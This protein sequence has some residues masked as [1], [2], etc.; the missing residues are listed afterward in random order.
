M[1][2]ICGII[3]P[4]RRVVRCAIEG[5]CRALRHRGPDGEGVWIGRGIGLGQTRLAVTDPAAPLNG[6]LSY[7]SPA[8]RAYVLVY[9]G[10]IYNAAEIRTELEGRGHIF[11]TRSDTE[12]AA[13][14]L[15]EWGCSAMFRFNGMWAL[16]LWDVRS[17]ELLLARD[18]FGVKPLYYAGYKNGLAFAS[19]VRTFFHLE[20]FSPTLDVE[21]CRLRLELRYA[22]EGRLC[23]TMLR[24]VRPL[25]SGS[26]LR[27]RRGG[28]VEVE[29]WWETKA[30][31]VQVPSSYKRQVD[32]F[33]ALFIDAVQIRARSEVRTAFGLS[34]GLDSSAVVC[35]AAEAATGGR[36]LWH[37]TVPGAPGEE[38]RYAE[39]VARLTG[40]RLKY[41]V[42]DADRAAKFAG[43][44]MQAMDEMTG[45]SGLSA[46]LYYRELASCGIKVSVEGHGADE[47]LGG[48]PWFDKVGVGGFNQHLYDQ[49]HRDSLPAILRHFDRL[50][51]AHGI[52]TRLPFLDWRLVVLA[53]SLPPGAKRLDGVRKRILRDAAG[54]FLPPEVLL[55]RDKVGFA[56]PADEFLRPAFEEI[57]RRIVMHRVWEENDVFD[58]RRLRPFALRVLSAPSCGLR[59]QRLRHWLWAHISLVAWQINCLAQPEDERL[60]AG[61]S[62]MQGAGA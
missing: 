56:G 29:K 4:R 12:T 58:G 41:A 32:Q 59:S 38:S 31:L 39:C 44:A 19:E 52:E 20:A 45:A 40:R 36:E 15:A 46:W 14:A 17:Q 26:L 9:N 53:M 3:T 35:M 47:L 62:V 34:G 8:G 23:G 37:L 49:F 2:G 54:D 6:P 13:A 50:S 7:V 21:H 51:M 27:M 55:R 5:F 42:C 1:C 33:R 16:G 25:P 18:R 57:G 61:A 60:V 30:H 10:E 43:Q 48:Y 22:A 28:A 11:R 24:G